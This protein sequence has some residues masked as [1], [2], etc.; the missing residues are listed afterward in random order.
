MFISLFNLHPNSSCLKYS[1]S[2]KWIKMVQ[3]L[4]SPRAS[5]S[6]SQPNQLSG[7]EN[8]PS[9]SDFFS[10][11]MRHRWWMKDLSASSKVCT[12]LNVLRGTPSKSDGRNTKRWPVAPPDSYYGTSSFPYSEIN[13]LWWIFWGSQNFKL[14]VSSNSLQLSQHSR[15]S[16]SEHRNSNNQSVMVAPYTYI[17]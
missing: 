12:H 1:N 14:P 11:S 3:R 7:C 16:Q 10:F 6:Y 9:S 8:W 2:S 15:R 4:Q 13:H 5:I 17:I